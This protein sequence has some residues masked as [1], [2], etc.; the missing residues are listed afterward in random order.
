MTHQGIY[1]SPNENI[2]NRNREFIQLLYLFVCKYT[3]SYGNGMAI[4]AAGNPTRAMEIL[5]ES[6]YHIVDNEVTYKQ[7]NLEPIYGA[8]Y[9]GREGI[10]SEQHYVE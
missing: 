7:E 8:T 4:V 6:S 5:E 3:I 2:P 10:I 1:V 9:R